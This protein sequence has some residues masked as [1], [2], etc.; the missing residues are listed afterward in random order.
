MTKRELKG[1]LEVSVLGNRGI[2][3]KFEDPQIFLDNDPPL[4]CFTEDMS[5]LDKIRLERAI[6][7]VYGMLGE[8]MIQDDL[9]CEIACGQLEGYDISEIISSEK[10]QSELYPRAMDLYAYIP[11]VLIEIGDRIWNRDS[12]MLVKVTPESGH[13]IDYLVRESALESYASSLD[14]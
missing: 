4:F 9:A 14:L 10:I 2:K 1:I 12:V 3:F 11:A 7:K 13:P 5:F 6:Q 8:N